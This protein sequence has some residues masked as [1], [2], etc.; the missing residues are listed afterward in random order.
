MPWTSCSHRRLPQVGPVTGFS[1]L[2][3]DEAEVVSK[4]GINKE[5]TLPAG[6]LLEG[7][8]GAWYKGLTL[9]RGSRREQPPLCAKEILLW[10]FWMRLAK[11]SLP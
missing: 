5:G 9:D 6:A 3:A 7:G 11:F 2:W 4:L 10:P 8:R 1:F